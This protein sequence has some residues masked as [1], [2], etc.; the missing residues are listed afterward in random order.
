MQPFENV[1]SARVRY[2][3]VV[4]ATRLV[5][6]CDP[7]FRRLVQAAFV[8]G[9]RYSELAALLVR[10]FNADSLTLF[11]SDNKSGR[12]RHISLNTEGGK[13]FTAL[14]AGKPATALIFTRADGVSWKENY[15]IRPMKEAISR[16][17]LGNEVTFHILRHSWA[18]LAVMNSM[19]LMVV[20][21]NLG[22]TD[23]R[24]VEKHYGHLANSYKTQM[25]QRHAPTFGIEADSSVTPLKRPA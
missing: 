10:D 8:T 20:A 6:A 17:K 19:P 5:N 16:A 9:A 2:L 11:V 25:I 13:L 18:S 12:P 22:H 4:E 3:T 1:D 14:V 21:A 7:D 15:H 24:M 23:T